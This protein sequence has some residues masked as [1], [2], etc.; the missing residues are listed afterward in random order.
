MPDPGRRHGSPSR[1]PERTGPS[2]FILNVL[3]IDDLRGIRDE[4]PVLRVGSA[5][6]FTEMTESDL[7]A[8]RFPS[9]SRRRLPW[10]APRSATGGPSA[11][12]SPTLR[13]PPTACPRPWPWTGTSSSIEGRRSPAVSRFRPL[14][15]GP[16]RTLFQAGELLTGGP[17]PGEGPCLPDGLRETGRRNAMARARMNLSIV[18]RQDRTA[19]VAE[20]GIVAGAVMPV[21]RRM[22]EAEKSSSG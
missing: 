14:S 8:R 1:A 4:G 11:A 12:I 17:F 19:T 5:T 16:Y 10:S 6:T 18:V 9:L 7:L 21:A 20:L 15:Q 2:G 22:G 13:P 3:E